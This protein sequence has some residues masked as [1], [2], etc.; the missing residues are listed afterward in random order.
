MDRAQE[1][2]PNFGRIARMGDSLPGVLGELRADLAEAWPECYP[3]SRSLDVLRERLMSARFQLA[4]LGQFKR[5]KSTFINALLGARVLPSAV[6]PLTALPT[7]IAW[8]SSLSVRVTLHGKGGVADLA[9]AST[10]AMHDELSGLVTETGNPLNRR[11]VARVDVFIPSDILAN[12]L[13]LIDTPGIGSTLRHNTDA[14]IGVLPE[15]D[16]ALFVVSA[17]PP[18]TEAEAAYLAQVREHVV[19]LHVVLNKVDYLSAAEL[20]EAGRFLRTTLAAAGVA[21]ADSLVFPI[22]AR[23]ALDAKACGVGLEESGVAAVER[24]I[25][26]DLARGKAA[27]LQ[28]SVSS[29]ACAIA[30][31][32]LADLSL[33]IRALEMPVADL[34]RRAAEFSRKLDAIKAEREAA[35]DQLIGDKARVAATLEAEAEQLREAAYEHLDAVAR[36]MIADGGG[37]VEAAREALAEAIP[38]F[39]QARFATAS[40]AFRETLEQLLAAH[41][42]RSDALIASVRETAANLFELPLAA[43]AD[44]D[45]I[46]LG[47]DPYWIGEE[48]PATFIGPPAALLAGLLPRAARERRLRKELDEMLRTLVRHNVENLRW[49]LL[50]GLDESFRAFAARLQDQL[51]DVVTATQGA[52]LQALERRRSHAHEIAPEAER[53]SR[54]LERLSALR[55]RLVSEAGETG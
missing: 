23:H 48:L 33:R 21:A 4:V 8:G 35:A 17:D 28:R 50:R 44:A 22:S 15:C 25:A 54:L 2:N 32:A 49:A 39:F 55:P 41:E 11:G 47:H 12:G 7:Y 31:Q 24:W 5:G 43:V 34:E 3:P 16:A 46:Q 26:D 20:D 42:A 10:E 6:V 30:D 45:P 9:P 27:S 18:L 14:A 36:Q 40:A 52:I 53:L 37:R 13:V 19:D 1:Q 29:K 38:D 51:A